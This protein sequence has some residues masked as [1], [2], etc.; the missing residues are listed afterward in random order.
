M[1]TSLRLNFIECLRFLKQG[2]VRRGQDHHGAPGRRVGACSPRRLT[3]VRCATVDKVNVWQPARSFAE[4]LEPIPDAEKVLR[5]ED[6][7]Q[8]RLPI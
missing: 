7:R 1:G 6:E 2:R 5:A 4:L 3:G 8:Q